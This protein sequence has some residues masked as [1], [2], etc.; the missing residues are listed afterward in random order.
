MSS[1]G[2][3]SSSETPGDCL[4]PPMSNVSTTHFVLLAVYT[5]TVLFATGLLLLPLL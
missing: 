5:G 1:L 2:I 4:R 3:R